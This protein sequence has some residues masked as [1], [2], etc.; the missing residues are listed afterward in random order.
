MKPTFPSEDKRVVCTLVPY[1]REGETLKFF[2][3]KRSAE[4]TQPH[5]L[6]L[7]GGGIEK[8]ETL[9][10]G[11]AR[12]VREELD[13]EISAHEYFSRYEFPKVINHVFILETTLDFSEQVHVLEGDWGKFL[14]L[15]EISADTSALMGMRTIISHVSEALASRVA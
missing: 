12:E 4:Q 9:E 5:T 7:F 8:D 6:G 2:V 11:L 1:T 13:I 14:S 3:Q 15:H 10:E